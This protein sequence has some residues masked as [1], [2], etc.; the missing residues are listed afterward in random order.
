MNGMIIKKPIRNVSSCAARVFSFTLLFFVATLLWAQSGDPIEFPLPD[1]RTLSGEVTNDLLWRYCVDDDCITVDPTDPD[2]FSALEQWILGVFGFDSLAESYGSSIL[3]N[4]QTIGQARVMIQSIT[5]IATQQRRAHRVTDADG[6]ESDD[7]A[8]GARGFLSLDSRINWFL[9]E[10]NEAN[11]STGFTT[12]GYTF[13]RPVRPA[14][15]RRSFP[16]SRHFGLS[17]GLSGVRDNEPTGLRTTRFALNWGNTRFS[18][19]GPGLLVDSSFAF[20]LGIDKATNEART[21][22]GTVAYT[23]NGP[24][25][26]GGQDRGSLTLPFV[27]SVSQFY[28]NN[29]SFIQAS[30]FESPFTLDLFHPLS[31]RLELYGVT[32][33]GVRWAQSLTTSSVEDDGVQDVFF[34]SAYTIDAGVRFY[35]VS[36]L[37]LRG[38]FS[39]ESYYSGET[40]VGLNIGIVY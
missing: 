16:R 17:V 29:D 26:F 30:V 20:S 4:S 21:A 36:G 23:V 2:Y 6:A 39:F 13:V 35:A 38:G 19:S 40:S 22:S 3:L 32:M 33:V 11:D 1:G 10:D 12:L 18:S 24:I 15:E 9:S 14:D 5:Q 31:S 8:A 28:P 37:G 27:I 7:S 34:V 25:R